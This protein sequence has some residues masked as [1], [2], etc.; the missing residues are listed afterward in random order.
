MSE[1]RGYTVWLTGLSGSGKSTLA[2]AL[3]QALI[4]RGQPVEILD[5]D[6]VREYLS[7]DLG[8]DRAGR[9]ANIKR[10]GY[11]ARLLARHGVAVITA[12][13][14]PYRETRETVRELH[15]NNFIEVYVQASVEACA[16]RDVKG[17]YQRALRGEIPQFTGVSDPYEAPLQPEVTVVTERE[18]VAQSLAKILAYLEQAG[19]L[20]GRDVSLG[21]A[22][23]G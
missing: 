14:S 20:P 15:G 10:I 7:T 12:A 4:Q 21:T 19:Y 17:L 23:N 11:V 16:K 9:D 18:T 13:I 3:Q 2:Q 5:G 1:R 6:E 8:F 22:G